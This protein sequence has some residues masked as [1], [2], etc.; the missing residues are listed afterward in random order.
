MLPTGVFLCHDLDV[1]L[2]RIV[3]ALWSMRQEGLIRLVR[4]RWSCSLVKKRCK[5]IMTSVAFKC[6]RSQN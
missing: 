2:G 4:P 1:Y 6:T 3:I 5:N